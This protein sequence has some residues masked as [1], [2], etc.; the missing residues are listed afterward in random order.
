MRRNLKFKNAEDECICRNYIDF[1]MDPTFHHQLLWK[2]IYVRFQEQ[3]MN[4]RGRSL[5]D[6]INR[7]GIIRQ[8]VSCY[9]AILQREG[10]TL[11]SG[12]TLME[13]QERCHVEYRRIYG[14]K[15][16]FEN[17]FEI[18]RCSP[19]YFKLFPF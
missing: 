6:L 14:E 16:H 19:N 3:T 17:C 7:F 18:L 8:E 10:P 12:E 2:R 4:L 1:T 11:R 9:V 15:I 5:S 13:F